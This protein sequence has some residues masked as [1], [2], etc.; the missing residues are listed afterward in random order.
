VVIGYGEQKKSLTTGAI[1]SVKADEL[2]TVSVGRIDQALQGRT[3]GVNVVPNS[4]SPGS[5]TKIRIRGTSS[6]GSSD[7]LYIIDGVRTG[8]GGMDYLS[9]NEIASIEV[10][11]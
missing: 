8:A 1:S 7:P 9:P 4:G 10:L 2:K 6:N 5:G 3:S 11:K